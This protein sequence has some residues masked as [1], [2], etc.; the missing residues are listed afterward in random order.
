MSTPGM[1]PWGHPWHGLVE[2]GLMVLPNDTIRAYPQPPAK[3]DVIGGVTTPIPDTHGSTYRVAVPGV[4]PLE[5]TPA[6]LA[7]DTA[8][9]R[10]WRHEATLSAA[11]LQLYGKPLDGWIY[12]DPD[13][14]RW[15]VRCA[16]LDENVLYSTAETLA[17]TVTLA[18]FGEL[19]G[20]A[21]EYEYPATITNW[22]ID[23]GTVPSTVRLL[24]DD[25]RGD[26]A[27]AVVMVH[28]RSFDSGATQDVR[29]AH[30][31]LELTITGPGSAALVAIS[32]IRSRSQVVQLDT[33][34]YT[35]ALHLAGWHKLAVSEGGTGEWEWVTYAGDYAD[36]GY[37]SN[38]WLGDGGYSTRTDGFF[39]VEWWY[40]L[41]ANVFSGAAS[42]DCNRIVALWYDATGAIVEV[43][44]HYSADYS[45]GW[46][47]PADGVRDSTCSLVWSASIE[48]GGVAVSTVEG[49]ENYTKFEE[50]PPGGSGR[51]VDTTYALVVDGVL[52]AGSQSEDTGLPIAQW[53][54]PG[55]TGVLLFDSPLDL[56]TDLVYED[57]F[58]PWSVP[59]ECALVRYANHVIGMRVIRQGSPTI[60]AFHPPA[61][62]S[63]TASG[64]VYVP[65]PAS[66]AGRYGSWCPFTQQAKWHATAP[67][68]YV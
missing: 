22:G 65:S 39:T 32:V 37:P 27:A 46:P 61:T 57:G 7:A 56:L 21:E 50:F 64:A 52:T 68:C 29:R 40:V 34:P 53:D 63:G 10:E 16:Q 13:G 1:P 8:A 54:K 62:P 23:S 42:V 47:I 17:L 28:Q 26:G 33:V 51:H 45:I 12:V 41:R 11:R 58:A 5:R 24:V 4:L 43:L 6:E 9:G 44:L 66:F 15:L 31:F 55:A 36:Y 49:S 30:S 3:T 60:Y 38:P 18:R 19:G 14:A 25:V 20:A 67:T 2:G 48:L 35:A 59:G